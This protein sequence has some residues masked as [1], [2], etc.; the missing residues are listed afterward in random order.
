M[1]NLLL[2]VAAM[3]AVMSVKAQNFPVGIVSGQDSVKV[4]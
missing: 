1:K 4:S 2:V 3:M